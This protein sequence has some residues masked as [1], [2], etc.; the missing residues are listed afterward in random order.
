MQSAW[1]GCPC[2]NGGG[3]QLL[4]FLCTIP[5]QVLLTI[6]CSQPLV[7]PSCSDLQTVSGLRSAEFVLR[8][9]EA[10]KK[11]LVSNFWPGTKRILKLIGKEHSLLIQHSGGMSI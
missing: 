10:V 2:G 5:K 1:R 4:R 7:K 9:R 3:R 11:F 8:A 6:D